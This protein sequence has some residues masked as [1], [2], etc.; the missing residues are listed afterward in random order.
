MFYEKKTDGGKSVIVS[1]AKKRLLHESDSS[2]GKRKLLKQRN[3]FFAS[4]SAA[5]FSLQSPLSTYS[6]LLQATMSSIKINAKNAL[7]SSC[8]DIK[9]ARKHLL[10]IRNIA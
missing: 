3:S 6:L 9:Y 5:A 4:F 10:F 7:F 1:V 2:L 8:L